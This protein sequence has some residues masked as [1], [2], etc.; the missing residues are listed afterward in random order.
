LIDDRDPQVKTLLESFQV[1]A[2]KQ[3]VSME[4]MQYVMES[5]KERHRLEVQAAVFEPF[6]RRFLASAGILN[7]MSILDVGTGVGDVAL[8]AAGMVG[9]T[10]RVLGVDCEDG[11]IN[12]A[13]QRAQSKQVENVQF[14]IGSLQPDENLGKFDFVIGRLVTAFQSDQVNFLH[15]VVSLVKAGGSIA[16]IEAAWNLCGTSTNPAIPVYD[17]LI[18]RSI[19]LIEA[20]GFDSELGSRLTQLF[21]HAG[22]GRPSVTAE[23]LVGGPDSSLL[24]YS[25]LNFENLFMTAKKKGLEAPDDAAVKMICAEIRETAAASHVQFSGPCVVGAFIKID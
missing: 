6:T 15:R 23:L 22:L 25:L 18:K 12:R 10:G 14:Q 9:P 5:E 16:F 24:D 3:R 17:D 2:K 7:G 19:S 4:K 1:M 21:A 13:K 8:L 11:M 20:L